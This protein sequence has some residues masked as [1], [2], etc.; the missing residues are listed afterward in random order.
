MAK[1]LDRKIPMEEGTILLAAVAHNYE[2]IEA[3]Y[4]QHGDLLQ[5]LQEDIENKNDMKKKQNVVTNWHHPSSRLQLNPCFGA[6]ERF[7]FQKNVS[8]A[9][10][11]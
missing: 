3:L 6:S 1:I 4:I 9:A 5:L 8:A 11:T 2:A 7:F 10:A